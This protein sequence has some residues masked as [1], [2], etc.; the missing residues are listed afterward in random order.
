MSAQT[1]FSP[2]IQAITP[3]YNSGG[4]LIGYYSGRPYCFISSWR[5]SYPNTLAALMQPM[6]IIFLVLSERF[7]SLPVPIFSDVDSQSKF[8]FASR[9]IYLAI[10]SPLITVLL[11]CL[12]VLF[13]FSN[14]FADHRQAPHFHQTNTLETPYHRALENVLARLWVSVHLQPCYQE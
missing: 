9:K 13:R 6:V 5:G 8:P 11:T 12:A 14:N 1:V 2:I 4:Y 10:A 7:F 3:T